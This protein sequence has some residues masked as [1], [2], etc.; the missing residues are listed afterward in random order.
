MTRKSLRKIGQLWFMWMIFKAYPGISQRIRSNLP[1]GTGDYG[2]ER[3]VESGRV[4]A[5]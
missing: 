1:S 3:H 2:V 5:S 4:K